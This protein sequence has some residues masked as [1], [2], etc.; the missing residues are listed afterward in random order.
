MLWKAGTALDFVFIFCHECLYE[1]NGMKSPAGGSMIASFFSPLFFFCSEGVLL[2]LDLSWN[3]SDDRVGG[4]RF[5]F[6]AGCK[7]LPHP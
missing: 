5:F 4:G 6:V 1:T 7:R 2:R 3:G